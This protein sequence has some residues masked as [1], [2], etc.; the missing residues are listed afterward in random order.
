MGSSGTGGGQLKKIRISLNEKYF[1]LY[2]IF[3]L[4]FMETQKT[5]DTKA[6]PRKKE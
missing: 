5:I 4:L 1:Y 6:V 3:I 2:E